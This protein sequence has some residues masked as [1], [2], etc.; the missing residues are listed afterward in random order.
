MD[1]NIKHIYLS[2]N[3][4]V[5][6]ISKH[7][8]LA[9]PIILTSDNSQRAH[10]Y[11]LNGNFILAE[12]QYIAWGKTIAKQ[13]PEPVPP[14]DAKENENWLELTDKEYDIVREYLV[15]HAEIAIYLSKG[16]YP[17]HLNKEG[18]REQR[19][20]FKKMVC[21]LHFWQI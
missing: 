16:V 8:G 12:G 11:P 17:K 15:K 4:T 2:S 13:E 14:S 19:K 10:I 18:L 21:T 6:E 5:A 3:V 1:S 7:L 20:T 9:P